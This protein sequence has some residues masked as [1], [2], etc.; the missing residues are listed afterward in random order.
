MNIKTLYAENGVW[1]TAYNGNAVSDAS[2]GFLASMDQDVATGSDVTFGSITATGAATTFNT[3]AIQIKPPVVNV[4]YGESGA[5]VTAG[6]AGMLVYRGSLTNQALLWNEIGDLA[7]KWSVGADVGTAGVDIF[8]LAQL[9]DVVP[10]AGDIPAYNDSGRLQGSAGLTAAVVSQLQ[11]IGATSIYSQQWG[12]V[13]VLDQSVATSATPQFN[14]VSLVGGNLVPSQGAFVVENI[15]TVAA[16]TSL[17]TAITNVICD[18]G[19]VTV[20][21]PQASFSLG[22]TFTIYFKTD[23]AGGSTV[24]VSTNG[25]DTID[26]SITVDLTAVG[27]HL[28]VKAVANLVWI[29]V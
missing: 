13:S 9:E 11:N 5:G 26:G 17:D 12:F 28:V 14:G 18:T 24:T 10:T 8:A 15:T 22:K 23:N 19:S 2:W 16:S 3:D 20:T 6:Q 7:G 29:V 4:N 1:A 27:Q 21:L 25:V